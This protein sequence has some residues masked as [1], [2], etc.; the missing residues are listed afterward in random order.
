MLGA[1]W[2]RCAPYVLG[3]AAGLVALA[4]LL[5][6]QR[7]AGRAEA[8][9]EINAKTL[10]VLHAQDQAAAAAPRGRDAVARRLRDS[11]F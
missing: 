7:R 9:A 3:A 4:S 5:G 6:A 8:V 1:L 11:G 10:E 2:A